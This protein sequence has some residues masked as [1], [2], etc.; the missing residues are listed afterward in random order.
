MYAARIA[1]YHPQSSNGLTSL[2]SAD[3]AAYYTKSLQA[4]KAVIDGGKHPLYKGGANMV[5]RFAEIFYKDQNSEI[6][7]AEQ[8]NRALGKT[9]TWAGYGMPDGVKA[10]WGANM[11]MYLA[12]DARFEHT[13]GS[14]GDKHLSLI[15]I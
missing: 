15:H 11:H 2:P 3:A 6:I 8:Y 13:D 7:F 5:D 1:K 9:H 12:S 10:G 4:A 14:P